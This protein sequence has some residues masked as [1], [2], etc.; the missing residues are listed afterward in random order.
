M[1]KGSSAR[2]GG[3]RGSIDKFSYVT[4]V[5]FYHPLE[6]VMVLAVF[7]GLMFYFARKRRGLR[8]RPN[9]GARRRLN[10]SLGRMRE[11]ITLVKSV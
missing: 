1:P 3:L 9:D 2:Q 8:K 7:L 6:I 4:T 10:L 5:L 11:D